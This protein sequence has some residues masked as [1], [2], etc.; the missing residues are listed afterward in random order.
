[1]DC[2]S[3]LCNAPPTF[4]IYTGAD[5]TVISENTFLALSAD[6]SFLCPGHKLRSIGWFRANIVCRGK[7]YAFPLYVIKGNSNSLLSC[8]NRVKMFLVKRVERVSTV[9]GTSGLLKTEPVEIIQPYAV[10]TARWKP[11][12]LPVMPGCIGWKRTT[13]LR[14]SGVL[15]WS[16]KRGNRKE[17]QYCADQWKLNHAVK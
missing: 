15:L 4:E 1:M 9:L 5:G 13:C 3:Q 6:T 17:V 14:Q 2:Y 8:P 10:Y 7:E 12:P 11:L 16:Q